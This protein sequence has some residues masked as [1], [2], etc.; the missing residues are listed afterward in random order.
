MQKKNP[1][2]SAD[3]CRKSSLGKVRKGVDFPTIKAGDGSSKKRVKTLTLLDPPKKQKVGDASVRP[4]NRNASVKVTKSTDENKV[5]LGD[6]LYN[7]YF[8]EGS[9]SVKSKEEDTPDSEPKQT[10][11]DKPLAKEKCISLPLNDASKQR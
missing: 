4:L 1:L 9:V 2:D 11:T 8:G 7:S 6:K 5:S 3:A 10:L